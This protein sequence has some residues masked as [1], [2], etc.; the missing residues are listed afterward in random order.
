MIL[1]HNHVDVKSYLSS[2]VSLVCLLRDWFGVFSPCWV[3]AQ[4]KEFGVSLSVL[5]CGPWLTYSRDLI[6][7][8]DL[9]IIVHLMNTSDLAYFSSSRVTNDQRMGILV[10]P[11]SEGVFVEFSDCLHA[12][13]YL[14][15]VVNILVGDSC[16]EHREQEDDGA[17]N[18]LCSTVVDGEVCGHADLVGYAYNESRVGCEVDHLAT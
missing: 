5:S 17:C 1:F 11:L 6:H 10:L 12:L 15:K 13:L 9:R 16:I 8:S 14:G 7:L 4:L 18:G 3:G 2:R